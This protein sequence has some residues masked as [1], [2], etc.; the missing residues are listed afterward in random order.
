[1]HRLKDGVNDFE[2]T[3]DEFTIYTLASESD[4]EI[5]KCRVK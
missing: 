1:M 4:I 3:A 2:E 5:V